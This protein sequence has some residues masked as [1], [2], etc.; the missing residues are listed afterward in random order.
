MP[1]NKYQIERIF[2]DFIK[3]A[4]KRNIGVLGIS[5]KAGTDD[6]R[7]SPVL[8]LT[9]ILIGKGYNVSIYDKNIILA[10]QKG[11]NKAL[12]ENELPHIN[13]RLNNSMED[14]INKSDIL[15]IGNTQEEF[16]N[17]DFNVYPKKLF[18]DLMRVNKDVSHNNY[19]GIAW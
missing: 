14:V 13:E 18:I 15:I 16:K 9:E 19:I 2:K 5:F 6:L 7:E 17:I 3:P 11:A 8:E 12:L 1:S 10:K 4:R